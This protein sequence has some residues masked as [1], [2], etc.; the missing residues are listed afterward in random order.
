MTT[1]DQPDKVQSCVLA[2]CHD[3]LAEW[4]EGGCVEHHDYEL[5]V[6]FAEQ[7]NDAKSA[8][9][10]NNVLMATTPKVIAK[11]NQQGSMMT[12]FKTRTNPCAAD[13]EGLL[14]QVMA[15]M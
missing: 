1:K 5:E 7:N 10:D 6:W 15:L 13:H 3:A 14:S 12:A 9:L 4:H 8:A 2:E 11:K